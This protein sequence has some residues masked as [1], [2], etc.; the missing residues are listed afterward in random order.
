MVRVLRHY[1]VD[2][3]FPKAQTCCGQPAFNAGFRREARRVAEHF[4][5]VFESAESIVCPSGSCTAM[6]K[7]YYPQLFEDIPTMSERFETLGK[8]TWEFS[9]FLTDVLGITEFPGELSGSTTWHDCCHSLRGLGIKDGPRRL[10]SSLSGGEFRELEDSEVCC[11]FGGLFSVKFDAISSAML[12]DKVE[13]VDRCG[14]DRLVA[15]DCSCLMHI[16]GGLERR[17]SEVRPMHIAEV[18]AE[19]L[20]NGGKGSSVS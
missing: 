20:E 16:G 14:A 8:K 7:E 10:L 18:L 1:G 12:E 2:V 6:V 11:G 19:A 5:D 13:R 15:T 4:L 3:D 9:Q 17:G